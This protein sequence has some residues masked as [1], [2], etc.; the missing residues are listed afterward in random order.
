VCEGDACQNSPAAPVDLTPG[1]LTFSGPG[2]LAPVVGPKPL[3]RAE[4]LAKALKVCR[5]KPRREQADCEGL[6]R[7]RYGHKAKKNG[8]K[9]ESEKKS[10]KHG[11]SVGRGR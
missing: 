5:S 4:D 9:K 7:A 11:E 3:T 1:S 8:K 6:A 10:S 2:N